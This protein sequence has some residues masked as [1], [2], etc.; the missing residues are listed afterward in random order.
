MS[1]TVL[2]I[3]DLKLAFSSEKQIL[4]GVS[5]SVSEQDRLVILG[6]SGSGK[7]TILRLILGILKPNHGSIRF[8]DKEINRLPRHDLNAVRQNI[9]MLY[10]HSALISSLSVKKNLALPLEELTDKP[11]DEIDHI[12]D[13][14]LSMVK[15]SQSKDQLP[16]ELSGGMKKRIGLARALVMNPQ[17]LLLDEPGAGLDPINSAHIDELIIEL[18]SKAKAAAIIVTHEMDSAF[19]IGTRMAMLHEGTIIVED[20]PEAF[21]RCTNPIVSKFI[22]GNITAN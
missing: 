8:K 5:L 18:T 19:R 17:L 16:E 3:E 21:K 22:N 13:E 2:Q 14:K 7:S 6:K 15:M 1:S 11:P 20:T 4:N 10:Q 9:G 12:I